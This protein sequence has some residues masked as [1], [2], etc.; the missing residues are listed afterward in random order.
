M[1]PYLKYTTFLIVNLVALIATDFDRMQGEGLGERTKLI[2]NIYTHPEERLNLV[3]H[4][5]R[6]GME[7]IN[8]PWDTE[9]RLSTER[10]GIFQTWEVS[11]EGSMTMC[12]LGS[13]IRGKS[14]L[15]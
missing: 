11:L 13:L 8:F 5:C 9:R 1:H 4:I 14:E 2:L 15:F 12:S 6:R 7:N 10:V 3:N